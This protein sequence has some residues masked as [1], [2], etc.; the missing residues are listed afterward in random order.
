MSQ[1]NV[2]T[3]L[4]S[5]GQLRT[6]LEISKISPDEVK[7]YISSPP[8]FLVLMK[9]I[10][11]AVPN[12]SSID[13]L[14]SISD[15]WGLRVMED[16]LIDLIGPDKDPAAFIAKFRDYLAY[17]QGLTDTHLTVARLASIFIQLCVKGTPQWIEVLNI[18]LDV[19]YKTV[20]GL[21]TN[22]S[23][24]RDKE[25][26]TSDINAVN[27]MLQIFMLVTGKVEWFDI[28]RKGFNITSSTVELDQLWFDRNPT[29]E[30]GIKLGVDG[31]MLKFNGLTPEQQNV[32]RNAHRLFA[33]VVQFENS[34][35]GFEIQRENPQ[36]FNAILNADPIF[37]YA[38]DKDLATLDPSNPNHIKAAE[39][40]VVDLIKN[41]SYDYIVAYVRIGI[42]PLAVVMNILKGALDGGF[43]GLYDA[44]LTSNAEAGITWKDK[45]IFDLSSYKTA[46]ENCLNGGISSSGGNELEEF[47]NMKAARTAELTVMYNNGNQSAGGEYVRLRDTVWPEQLRQIQTRQQV[48]AEQ[49]IQQTPRQQ[50]S[51]E[52]FESMKERETANLMEQYKTNPAAGLEFTRLNDNVW[53]GQEAEIRAR[54]SL[55]QQSPTI[56]VQ[57]PPVIEEDIIARHQRE[58]A[59][60]EQMKANETNRLM[61]AYDG[62]NNPAA[63]VEYSRLDNEVWPQELKDIQERQSMELSL[64]AQP[65]AQ[66][67]SREEILARNERELFE[68]NKMKDEGRE[69]LM[70]IY[71]EQT[72]AGNQQAAQAAV[73]EYT[74][75]DNVV[76]PEQ[77]TQMLERQAQELA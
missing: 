36:L 1:E 71:N 20:S 29:I 60:F 11:L 64:V 52:E 6:L 14:I 74:N 48:V 32:L 16:S 76:W 40:I 31:S 30:F 21:I 65:E 13:E 67:P 62:G 56:V 9:R 19:Y 61:V 70:G 38:V 7:N 50:M 51:L 72:V 46:H 8:V 37:K 77:Y 63:G 53:P 73:N 15:K 26:I 2:V 18:L 44:L 22:S 3:L 54:Q 75:L 47:E 66:Q 12:P 24:A 27:S 10:G 17:K 4:A 25:A 43:C 58:L 5:T 49:A 35:K 23:N 28:F 68:F 69:R 39:S 34:R 45:T 59:E 42:L 57:P 55:S 33:K 41:K